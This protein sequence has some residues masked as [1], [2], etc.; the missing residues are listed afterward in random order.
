MSE[1]KPSNRSRHE[2]VQ[3]IHKTRGRPSAVLSTRRVLQERPSVGLPLHPAVRASGP[4]R[5]ESRRSE[6]R[7]ALSCERARLCSGTRSGVNRPGVP[8]PDCAAG[9][10]S[11]TRTLG[12]WPVPGLSA[13]GEPR[14]CPVAAAAAA[15]AAPLCGT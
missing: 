11:I 15:R 5:S 13:S 7:L 9:P 8:L 12:Q 6:S 10:K 4:R 1:S 14:P 2:R 3:Q